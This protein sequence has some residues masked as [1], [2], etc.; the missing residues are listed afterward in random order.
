MALNFPSSPTNGQLYTSTTGVTY[1]YNGTYWNAIN[2]SYA[3][4]GFRKI[5]NISSQFNGSNTTFYLNVSGIPTTAVNPQNL[6]ISVGGI[7]Q[8]P[9]NAYTVSANTITFTTAPSSGMSFFGTLLGDVANIGIPSDKTVGLSTL[10]DS[11]GSFVTSS[12]AQANT[13]TT[14]AQSAYD[15]A[16][17]GTTQAQASFLQANNA[18][19]TANTKFN[20]SGGTI[21]GPVQIAS[22]LIVTG[23]VTMSGN[24]TT[25]NANNLSLQDNMFYLNSG[26][27]VANPDLGFAGNY[28]DG[29]YHHTGFFRDATDGIWKVFDSYLPEPDASPY[30]DTSNSSFKLATFQ[31]N[32]IFVANN[33]GI[34]TTS[35]SFPLDI[36]GPVA[37]IRLAPSV[38]TNSALLRLTNTGGSAYVGLDN[39]AGGLT[40]PYSLNLYHGGA[41]PITFSTSGT[42]RMRLDSSGN[43]GIGASPTAKLTVSDGDLRLTQTVGGDASGVNSYSLYFKTPSGDLAQLFATS[44]GGGGPSGFGGALRFY[45]K[46]NNST[47]SERAR[48]DSSGNL[49]IGKTSNDGAPLQVNVSRTSSTNALALILSDSVTG[50]QTNGVY[51]AIRA[52]SNAGNSVSEIRFLETDGTN[53][54]TG[55]AFATQA[56]AGGLTERM[57]INP[58]GAV[59]LQGG[60]SSAGGVGIAFPG[61]QSASSDANTLDDYEEGTYTPTLLTVSGTPSY[62]Y[63][64]AYYTKIGRQITCGGIVGISNSTSLTGTISI[65]LPFP[66]KSS[67]YGQ[68][69]GCVS[70]ANGFTMPIAGAVYSITFQ[71]NNGSSYAIAQCLGTGTTS[72]AYN[73]TNV[74][75]SWYLRFMVTY[76]TTT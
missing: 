12:Y 36:A 23:N 22:S 61:T 43:L 73:S 67:V 50:G 44:E 66:A 7:T 31:A 6:I 57:R 30:I 21:T 35:P 38:N 54:N 37:N 71:I 56:V 3:T 63:Q 60:T 51:K 42:E 74:A 5:D 49:T 24:V 26:S 69:A 14:Q 29:T 41:Y 39:S 2:T 46:T 48:I 45:T 47:L 59:V 11:F 13:A 1:Q 18:Y 65:S 58:S 15:Q 34:G 40:V 8:E 9:G 76:P 64:E 53:N 25:I 19:T 16:N 72:V 55:L 70:D 33:V 68:A 28:N 27:N 20:S 62:L 75:A 4:G 10:T 32:N 17:T 52:I